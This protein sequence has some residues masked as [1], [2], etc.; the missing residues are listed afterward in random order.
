M[1]LLILTLYVEDFIYSILEF[2][3]QE[4]VEGANILES[5]GMGQYISNIPLFADFIGFMKESKNR[6]KTILALIP[7]DRIDSIIQGIE[8][9]TGDLDKKQG[10]MI[11]TLDVSFYKGTMKMM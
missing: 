11:M 5:F 10:A 6:S 3:I 1:K 2:F 7:E 8:D 4:G 9:I